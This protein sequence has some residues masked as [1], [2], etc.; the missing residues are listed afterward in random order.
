[1]IKCNSYECPCS[2]IHYRD[3]DVTVYNRC[4]SNLQYNLSSDEAD[5]INKIRLLS[6]EN[7]D[8]LFKVA[9]EYI[10]LISL[11]EVSYL[12]LKIQ[13]NLHKIYK[14][15]AEYNKELKDAY[16]FNSDFYQGDIYFGSLC[17]SVPLIIHTAINEEIDCL[18][19]SEENNQ[20]ISLETVYNDQEG[21]NIAVTVG[22]I[23]YS[24]VYPVFYETGINPRYFDAREEFDKNEFVDMYSEIKK[25][26]D[27]IHDLTHILYFDLDTMIYKLN[28]IKD[29]E[30]G[31]YR[32]YYF[33]FNPGWKFK[34]AWNA[35]GVYYLVISKDL[36]E[37]SPSYGSYKLYDTMS[38][39]KN[40]YGEANEEGYQDE[41]RWILFTIRKFKYRR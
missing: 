30:D 38:Y 13:E 7:K 31:S 16:E 41:P 17:R 11:K 3:D 2:K 25:I 4:L 37:N 35:K 32:S 8:E 14:L 19:T 21:N 10:D 27:K 40:Y 26:I 23:E 5:Y 18:G 34:D 1:M 22:D 9:D 28:Q 6:D 12:N 20:T 33:N 24:I 39:G 36:D 29:N 15:F